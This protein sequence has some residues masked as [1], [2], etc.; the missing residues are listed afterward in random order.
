MARGYVQPTD[1]GQVP[2]R[3]RGVPVVGVADGRRARSLAVPSGA[4]PGDPL[5]AVTLSGLIFEGGRIRRDR[6][7][8]R[9]LPPPRYDAK[10]QTRTGPTRTGHR[11]AA[12]LMEEISS[13][14]ESQPAEPGPA[15]GAQGWSPPPVRILLPHSGSEESGCSLEAA[16]QFAQL[17]AAEVRVVHVREYDICRGARFFL[18]SQEEAVRLTLDA[19]SRLRRRGVAATGIVRNAPR[20]AVPDA[21]LE[22]A[23]DSKVS[24]IFLGAHHRRFVDFLFP[25]VVRRVLRKAA[26]PVLVVRT[27]PPDGSHPPRSEAPHT[28][29]EDRAA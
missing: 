28:K 15:T 5:G 26:C 1:G 12:D 3:G 7:R 9:H 10:P 19:V 21:I 17:M 13:Y 2:V 4:V 18:D 16:V 20:G 29:R 24:L 11:E 8:L 25:N 23:S 14:L 6:T 27:D 22:E